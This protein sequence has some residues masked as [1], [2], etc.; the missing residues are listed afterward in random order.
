MHPSQIMPATAN[1]TVA[2]CREV[3]HEYVHSTTV[4]NH[5]RR[6]MSASSTRNHITEREST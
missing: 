4:I 2:D 1:V 5:W 6:V 3:L